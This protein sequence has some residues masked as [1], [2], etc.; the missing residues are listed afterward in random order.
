[1]C[2]S[3]ISSATP[4]R[5]WPRPTPRTHDPHGL[6]MDDAWRFRRSTDPCYDVY[7]KSVDT[8]EP[9]QLLV[10]R[11]RRQ[12][13]RGL[14]PDGKYL[15]GTVLRSGLWIYPLDPAEKPRLVRGSAK[16]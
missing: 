14:V 2:G 7:V 3:T 16:I 9:E 12:T 11:T 13:H 5:V 1:M 6:L 4:S 10:D 8:T 15:S